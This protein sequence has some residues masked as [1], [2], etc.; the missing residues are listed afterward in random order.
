M[1]TKLFS[2]LFSTFPALTIVTSAGLSRD[3]AVMAA[4]NHMDNEGIS[5]D[6]VGVF[7]G[8]YMPCTHNPSM[9]SNL[10]V[11]YTDSA[12]DFDLDETRDMIV[13]FWTEVS[14]QLFVASVSP[15]ECLEHSMDVKHLSVQ[16]EEE[17]FW[18]GSS[19]KQGLTRFATLKEAILAG[20]ELIAE[21]E[22][23]FT[24][25]EEALQPA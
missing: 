20:D 5:A 25:A 2:V 18:L 9:K 23:A 22:A 4:C 19:A 21:Y 1:K 3:H 15:P 17:A 10:V 7:E 6:P 13:D 11:L 8:S 12:R 14:P 24:K 16:F